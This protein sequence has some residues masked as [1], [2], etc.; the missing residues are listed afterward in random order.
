M[1]QTLL[2]APPPPPG[3]ALAITELSGEWASCSV[4]DQP[5]DPGVYDYPVCRSQPMRWPSR[6]G[7]LPVGRLS[8]GQSLLDVSQ[9]LRAE[10]ILSLPWTFKSVVIAGERTQVEGQGLERG[11]EPRT[12]LW[13]SSLGLF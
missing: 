11:L 3:N 13:V 5:F 1:F 8:P 4:I 9:R 6:E 2:T 7:L 10:A 12:L